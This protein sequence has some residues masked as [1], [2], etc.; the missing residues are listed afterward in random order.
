M[1]Y[2]MDRSGMRILIDG[3]DCFPDAQAD[4]VA[5]FCRLHK[6]LHP[7][8][9]FLLQFHLQAFLPIREDA[10]AAYT[11]HIN[12]LMA[13]LSIFYRPALNLK[14]RTCA[15]LKIANFWRSEELRRI[16]LWLRLYLVAHGFVL[17]LSYF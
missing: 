4:L 17:R 14:E 6:V 1:N 9:S 2:I 7:H 10:D 13:L 3:A 8:S 12:R 15:G 5:L 16:K 11:F